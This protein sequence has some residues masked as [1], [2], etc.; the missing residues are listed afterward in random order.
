MKTRNADGGR[1]ASQIIA[2]GVMNL[3]EMNGWRSEAQRNEGS[4]EWSEVKNTIAARTNEE[5]RK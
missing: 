5:E 1:K 2:A 4:N 3:T